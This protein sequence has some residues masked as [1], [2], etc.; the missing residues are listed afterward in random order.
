MAQNAL[1]D[2]R[3]IVALLMY[4]SAAR[5]ALTHFPPL[6]FAKNPAGRIDRD[7]LY[8]H[9]LRYQVLML[10]L[11]RITRTYAYAAKVE[12]YS[13]GLFLLELAVAFA[14]AAQ[15]R[16]LDDLEEKAKG[17]KEHKW[18]LAVFWGWQLFIFSST[19]WWGYLASQGTP[20][21][22]NTPVDLEV[23]RIIGLATAFLGFAV[24]WRYRNELI[25]IDRHRL[26]KWIFTLSVVVNVTW[27]FFW[28]RP[29]IIP[30]VATVA[31]GGWFRFWP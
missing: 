18:N 30:D 19:F 31:S 15:L 22:V 11:A 10:L 3:V 20:A 25:A 8:V 6:W 2:P 28:K 13:I 9:A 4:T 16:V 1:A 27:Y 24:E 29:W 12:A 23:G 5:L 7:G 17:G 26:W 14:L 21:L